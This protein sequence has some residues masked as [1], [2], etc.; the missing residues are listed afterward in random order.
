LA[1]PIEFRHYLRLFTL[2]DAR[3]GVQPLRLPRAID[4]RTELYAPAVLQFRYREK[5]ATVNGGVDLQ[6]SEWQDV[7]IAR[8]G[9][10]F[11]VG[12]VPVTDETIRQ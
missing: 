7:P 5:V 12:D 11:N 9:D 10:V 4:G 3:N 8:E 6:W 2:D 1:S